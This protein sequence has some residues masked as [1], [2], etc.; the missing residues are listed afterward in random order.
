MEQESKAQSETN[1]LREIV[2]VKRQPT[3]EFL[4]EDGDVECTRRLFQS[5]SDCV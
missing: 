1:E 3:D 4:C 5:L 2:V